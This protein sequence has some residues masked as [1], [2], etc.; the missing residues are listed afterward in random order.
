LLQLEVRLD[1][2]GWVP[3]H[4]HVR[5]DERVEVLEG[6]LTVRVAGKEQVLG[7]GSSAD[8]PRRRLHTV[9]NAGDRDVR[10]LM[11]ARPA[12]HL[13]AAM[14]A[15]FGVLGLLRPLARLRRGR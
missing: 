12:R 13:E 9:R 10:F 5:Q 15:M 2:G 14:R 11:E 1:P 8:V 6:S 4:V 7:V 3:L